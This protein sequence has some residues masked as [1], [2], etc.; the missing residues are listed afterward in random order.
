MTLAETEVDGVPTDIGYTAYQDQIGW[1]R[2]QTMVIV[3]AGILAGAFTREGPLSPLLLTLGT[4]AVYYLFRLVQR[5]WQIRDKIGDTLD[6]V[7]K[8]HGVDLIPVPAPG[9]LRGRT[10]VTR[11]AWGLI[12]TNLVLALV[13]IAQLGARR[14]SAPTLEWLLK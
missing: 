3:E 11:I 5:D 1:S 13:K 14:S 6:R 12:A 4:F 2:T 7:T 9:M 8:M 10:I